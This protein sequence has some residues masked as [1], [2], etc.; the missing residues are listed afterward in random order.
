VTECGEPVQRRALEERG[1]SG[2]VRLDRAGESR[3]VQSDRV[4]SVF[5]VTPSESS[6]WIHAATAS[7]SSW[8]REARTEDQC[9]A[10]SLCKYPGRLCTRVVTVHCVV[11]VGDQGVL[12]GESRRSLTALVIDELSGDRATN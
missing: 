12:Y 2:A 8:M 11:H 6:V 1:H 4:P 3:G 9:A 10:L 5:V 7:R